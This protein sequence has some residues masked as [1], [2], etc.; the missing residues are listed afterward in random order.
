MAT[1]GGQADRIVEAFLGLIYPRLCAH[2]GGVLGAGERFICGGCTGSSP[3]VREPYCTICG[4]PFT[5]GAGTAH[6]CSVCIKSPPPYDM[7]RAPMVYGGAVKKAVHLYKYRHK[8]SLIGLLGG[9]VAECSPA[10]FG[11]TEVVAAVPL[12]KLRLAERGFNQ[13][14]FLARQAAL[15]TGAMLS[16]D[17]LVRLR[18]TR[19]QMDLGPSE[20]E[21]NVRGAFCV[22]RP[23]EFRGRSVLLVDDV[24][25]T[26][27]TVKECCRVL[28]AAGARSVSV[29]TVAR[30]IK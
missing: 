10:W 15:S 12:H 17:G 11:G 9:Y 1:L 24:Y 20:R 23:E 8:R 2:C 30:T 27:A 19:P 16:V 6:P 21:L 7:A 29:L 14:L 26:G 4:L 5:D 28:K 22:S 18:H 3:R 13:S 25:T